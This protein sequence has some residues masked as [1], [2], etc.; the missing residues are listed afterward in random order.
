MSVRAGKLGLATPDHVQGT[1]PRAAGFG[2]PAPKSVTE[3]GTSALTEA[4][5]LDAPGI[6][7]L[8]DAD[9]VLHGTS[10]AAA[11]VWPNS[12][13]NTSRLHDLIDPTVAQEWLTHITAVLQDRRPLA[14]RGVIKGEWLWSTFRRVESSGSPL[15]LI[16]IRCMDA[17][18]IHTPPVGVPAATRIVDAVHHDLG[19]L[20]NLSKR[21]IEVLSLVGAGLTTGQIAKSLHRSLKTVENHR[22]SIGRKLNAR[23]LLDLS[24][25]ARRAGMPGST[26]IFAERAHG[27]SDSADGNI[28]DGK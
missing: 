10:A 9:G 4:L 1:S 18:S 16:T 21:E 6:V 12:R 8:A 2:V 15:V 11:I 14:V 22:T 25:I 28:M 19:D 23:S 7:L 27:R 24:R 5:L 17:E 3:S 13:V 26:P 20:A